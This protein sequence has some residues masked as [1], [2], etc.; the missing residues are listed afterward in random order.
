MKSSLFLAGGKPKQTRWRTGSPTLTRYI[1]ITLEGLLISSPVLCTL[2][3]GKPSPEGFLN[4][5]MEATEAQPS[6][7]RSFAHRSPKAPFSLPLCFLLP[8]EGMR[9]RDFCLL[10]AQECYFCYIVVK[11]SL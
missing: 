3:I 2:P 7:R 8:G 4:L 10:T 9:L 5:V 11:S 6:F 1:L